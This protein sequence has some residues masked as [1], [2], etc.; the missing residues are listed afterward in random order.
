MFPFISY[1]LFFAMEK[2]IIHLN[3]WTQAQGY[4]N[5][6]SEQKVFTANIITLFAIITILIS[7]MAITIYPIQSIVPT[8]TMDS[9]II[10]IITLFIIFIVAITIHFNLNSFTGQT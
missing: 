7:I 1:N 4:L 6:F 5:I 2:Q 3:I 8:I 9:F 10:A